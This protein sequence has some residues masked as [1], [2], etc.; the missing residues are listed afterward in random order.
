ME[1]AL[2]IYEKIVIITLIVLM[3]SVVLFSTID[4]GW[5]II[6][7]LISSPMLLLDVDELLDI[8]GFFLLVLVGL[9]LL[10]TISAYLKEHVVHVEIVLEVA[11]IAI[12]RKI[13]IL[14]LSDYTPLTL[15]GIAAIVA[16]LA[17]AFFLEKKGRLLKK[18]NEKVAE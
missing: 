10:E 5:L 17:V 1:K 9:E 8:F 6:K 14:N 2:R 13:V 12:A 16:A 7:D 18:K 3:M 4:L 11:L 15:L